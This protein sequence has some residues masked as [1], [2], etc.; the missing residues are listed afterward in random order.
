M[1]NMK[2]IHPLYAPSYIPDAIFARVRTHGYPLLSYQVNCKV[3]DFIQYGDSL[4]VHYGKYSMA[5]M[6][7]IIQD[8]KTWDYLPV[9]Y[10]KCS[11]ICSSMVMKTLVTN[12]KFYRVQV[13]QCP[14]T[15]RT[16]Q[17]PFSEMKIIKCRNFMVSPC[18][19]YR[20]VMSSPCKCKDKN[21]CPIC[22]SCVSDPNA[23]CP[24][25]E[26]AKAFN[27]DDILFNF[28]VESARI[29]LAD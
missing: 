14:C 4:K 12:D 24:C 21:G 13:T 2:Q 28:D 19:E 29:N 17:R 8:V 7:W 9:Y 15:K 11:N 25:Q 26:S 10:D 23:I 5:R 3:S 18:E 27:A 22:T 20:Q 16:I 6:Y 1:E